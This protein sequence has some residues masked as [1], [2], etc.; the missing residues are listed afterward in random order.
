MNDFDRRFAEMQQERARM[1]RDHEEMK[2]E[3]ARSQRR[4]ENVILA[5][6]LVVTGVLLFGCWC[7]YHVL[8]TK[9][10]VP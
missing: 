6:C 2:R 10:L 5:V 7:V 9:K 1:G 3:V 8:K 4:F